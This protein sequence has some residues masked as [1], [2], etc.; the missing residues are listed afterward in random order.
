MI[1]NGNTKVEVEEEIEQFLGKKLSEVT[2][3]YILVLVVTFIAVRCVCENDSLSC[4]FYVVQLIN[5]G[6]KR[7]K[8]LKMNE[9][10]ELRQ[11]QTSPANIYN[12]CNKVWPIYLKPRRDISIGSKDLV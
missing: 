6:R 7:W 9:F 11:S 8:K 10:A 2:A 5:L 1:P 4:L 3:L 12:I